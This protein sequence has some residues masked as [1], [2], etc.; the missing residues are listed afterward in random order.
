MAIESDFHGVVVV[1]KPAGPTSHDIVLVARRLFRT[2]VGHTGTLDPIA[3]GVL[4]IVLGKA[5]RLS[6]YL[7]EGDKEYLATVRLGI[8]T[9]TFDREGQTLTVTPVPPFSATR[10][11]DSLDSFRGTIR[12]QPPMYSAVKLK[13]EPLYKA[14]RRG[15]SKERKWREVSIFALTVEEQSEDRLRLRIHCSRGTY[16]RVL[17]HELGQRL[18]C[19][20]HLENLR[21]TRV[22][23]FAL[24]RA[25]SLRELQE[26]DW[27]R[28]SIPLEELLTEWTR[29]EVDDALA[30][31]IARGN[32]VPADLSLRTDIVRLFHRGKLLA[33]ARLHGAELQ[34]FAVLGDVE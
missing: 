32:R 18:G 2:K 31:R 17:A 21:R 5:T 14:A 30:R 3:T 13:G 19:G 16:I 26:G 8:T 1:D 29:L 28:A 4:P 9:D 15:E 24:D 34:P 10:L 6:S 22:G 20:A 12:Q 7:Q 33:L 25:V 27:Q 23:A 11:E